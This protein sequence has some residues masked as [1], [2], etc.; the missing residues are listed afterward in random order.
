MKG[1]R[2]HVGANRLDIHFSRGEGRERN[3]SQLSLCT[4]PTGDLA[5]TPGSCPDWESNPRPFGSQA[6]A[7]STEPYQPGSKWSGCLPTSG[8]DGDV[9]R[10]TVPPRTMKRRTPS[11][12]TKNDQKCQKID[13]WKSNHQGV[14]EAAF[15]QTG[16]RSRDGQLG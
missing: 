7:Q 4:L 9:G 16:R 13:I 14:K 12:K 5:C 3:I 1:P 11:L 2:P 8:Q 15:I 6:G 10:Y